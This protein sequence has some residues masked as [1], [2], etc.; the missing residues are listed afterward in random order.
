MYV[1]ADKQAH[2][3]DELKNLAKEVSAESGVVCNFVA[4]KGDIYEQDYF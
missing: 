3:N 1:F 4:I 2:S